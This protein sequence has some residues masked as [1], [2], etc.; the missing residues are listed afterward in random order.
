MLF[1]KGITTLSCITGKEHK[2]ICCILLGL[3]IDLPLPDGRAASHILK[4]VC[5]LLDFLFLAQYPSHT[6]DTLHSLEESSH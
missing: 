1:S 6:S 5:A 3:I 4:A 2:A